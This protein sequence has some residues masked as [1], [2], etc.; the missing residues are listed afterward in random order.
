MLKKLTVGKKIALGFMVIIGILLTIAAIGY[1]D[2][3]NSANGFR[4]YRNLSNETNLAGQIQAKILQMS[5]NVKDYIITGSQKVYE[6]FNASLASTKG[7]YEE[8]KNTITDSKRSNM[9]GSVWKK[10]TDYETSFGRI[11]KLKEERNILVNEVLYTKG[12]FIETAMADILLSAKDE[13]DAETVY[14][15]GVAMKHLLLARLYVDRFLGTSEQEAVDRVLSEIEKM[16]SPIGALIK[17]LVAPKRQTL[18]ANVQ[19]AKQDYLGNFNRLVEVVRDRNQV[20]ENTLDRL[21]P[22]IAAETENIKL[23][24]MNDQNT[25][26]ERIQKSNVRSV[27]I[28]LMVSAFAV[29]LGI[30]LSIFII[31]GITA[32]LKRV[33]RGVTATSE[34]VTD[35]SGEV[36]GAS[37]Q[38]AEEASQQAASLEETSASLE[39][40]TSM[41]RQNARNAEQAE[42]IVKG[43]VGKFEEAA[44][45][46]GELTE[47]M[48]RISQSSEETQKVV[49]TIDEI[50]FQTNLLAL[51]AAVEAARAGEAGAGFA[52]VADEVRN[53]ALR[54]ADAAKNTGRIIEET[55]R[56]V[57]EGSGSVLRADETFAGVRQESENVGQLVSQIAAASLEQ[58]DGIKQISETVMGMDNVTMQTAAMAEETASASQELKQQADNMEQF[59]KEL[60]L[61]VGAGKEGDPAS[62]SGESEDIQPLS[63]EREPGSKVERARI[64]C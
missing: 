18:L 52:V 55:I 14:Q 28:I 4:A 42:T 59:I 6:D 61:L 11:V 53:L 38:L 29:I 8:A 10:L 33:I 25:L 49:K 35:A 41:T 50:A 9:I 15:A 64:S 57:E 39:E 26:G 1:N 51:N 34:K 60:T 17:T 36:S 43:S 23:S 40:V 31:R 32:P 20:V 13:F 54:A 21:G 37:Q 5:T 63:T 16:E 12:Q 44:R 19:K 47:S 45:A 46:M 24:V 7:F 62:L 48:K 22:E 3:M 2:L 58:N 56:K 30:G 27:K